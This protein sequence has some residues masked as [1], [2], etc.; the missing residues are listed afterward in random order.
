MKLLRHKRETQTQLGIYSHSYLFMRRRRK[1]FL[2]WIYSKCLK[3]NALK[4]INVLR[5]SSIHNDFGRKSQ[6]L[7]N[8][9]ITDNF[10][11]WKFLQTTLNDTN[12]LI[13]AEMVHAIH[14]YVVFHSLNA[15]ISV[16]WCRKDFICFLRAFKFTFKALLWGKWGI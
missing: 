3:S 8:D 1:F 11:K 16:I 7:W 13:P 12:K 5:Y 9:T 10:F 6:C 2:R 14:I 4:L 15:G